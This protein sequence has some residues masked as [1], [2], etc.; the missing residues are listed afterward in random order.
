MTATLPDHAPEWLFGYNRYGC[1]L[2]H[3]KRLP[4]GQ[5]EVAEYVPAWGG[6][7]RW[8]CPTADE[9][10]QLMRQRGDVRINRL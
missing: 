8:S 2:R 9:A 10:E 7:E 1:S 6:F 3:A 5:Y 4:D